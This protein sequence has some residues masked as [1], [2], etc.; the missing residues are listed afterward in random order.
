[1]KVRRKNG[2]SRPI[3]GMMSIKLLSVVFVILLVVV[4]VVS[5]LT[6]IGNQQQQQQKQQQQVPSVRGGGGAVTTM[7]KKI[8]IGNDQQQEIQHDKYDELA[9]ERLGADEQDHEQ[10]PVSAIQQQ[11]HDKAAANENNDGGGDAVT[12]IGWAVT[13]TG[14]GVDPITEGA[15]VLM[16]SI[17]LAS[18]RGNMNGRYDYK[19]Y[20]IYHPDALKCAKTLES[21]GYE[22]VERETPV[23]VKDIQGEYLKSKIHKNGC[24]GEKELVKLE[25]YTLTQHPIIVHMDLDTLVLKPLDYLFDWMLAD[26]SSSYDTSDVPIMWK[27]DDKPIKVNAMFTRD[28]KKIVYLFTI[29]I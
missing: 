17:H 15:A 6:V 23:A 20:A 9:V 11:Q 16:H 12:T 18:I 14:C 21:L 7:E 22:L 25:A 1:M 19:M 8:M 27:D 29:I 4:Y 13:I 3:I 5:F 28:C 10:A 26:D 24:C 2:P